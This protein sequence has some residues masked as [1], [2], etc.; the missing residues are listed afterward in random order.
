MAYI[1]DNEVLNLERVRAELRDN[2][3]SQGI[4][5]ADDEQMSSLAKKVEDIKSFSKVVEGTLSGDI[6]YGEETSVPYA[7]YNNT[8]IETANC[9]NLT[10]L[11]ALA[12]SECTSLQKINLPKLTSMD[13]KS[14]ASSLF[15]LQ[16]I[17]ELYLKNIEATFGTGYMLCFNYPNIKRYCVPKFTGSFPNS[18]FVGFT[19]LEIFET[20]QD[21]TSNSFPTANKLRHLIF[22][23]KTNPDSPTTLSNSTYITKNARFATTGKGGIIFVPRNTFDYTTLTNWA[24]CNFI[25][26][27]IEGSRYENEDWISFDREW[28]ECFVDNESIGEI[29]KDETVEVFKYTENYTHIYANGVELDDDEIMGDYVGVNLTTTI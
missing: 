14:S 6:Y 15:N 23:R 1:N 19:K 2:L 5:C 7:F 17:I 22:R 29:P 26:K 9:P 11:G 12:F 20:G 8:L 24:V 21:W 13:I 18:G 3:R 28:F 10:T 4:E 27:D 25:Q 16:N